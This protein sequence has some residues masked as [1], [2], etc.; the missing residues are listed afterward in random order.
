MCSVTIEIGADGNRYE[1]SL[2]FE[3]STFGQCDLPAICNWHDC[4]HSSERERIDIS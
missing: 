1:S 4:R 3:C 2:C